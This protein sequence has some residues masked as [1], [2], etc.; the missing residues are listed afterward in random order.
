MLSKSKLLKTAILA[1]LVG[2]AGAASIAPASAH[3]Y[4]GGGYHRDRD[5]GYRHR[6]RDD[7]WFRHDRDGR[8]H[9]HDRDD[10][11]SRHNR[12]WY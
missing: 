7:G 8:H 2:V 11:G 6:D 4:D 9:R 10:R 12:G 3:D 1:A 5:D